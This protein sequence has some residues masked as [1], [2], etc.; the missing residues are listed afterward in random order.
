MNVASIDE[1]VDGRSAKHRVARASSATMKMKKPVFLTRGVTGD[2]S[3]P[4]IT[5]RRPVTVEL[6]TFCVA[7]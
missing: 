6:R 7:M 1:T 3:R 4:W 5:D 2:E